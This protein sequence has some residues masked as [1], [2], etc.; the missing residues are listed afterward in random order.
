MAPRRRCV[1]CGGIVVARPRRGCPA[2]ARR[3]RP[4]RLERIGELK[5]AEGE[6]IAAMFPLWRGDAWGERACDDGSCA[7]CQRMELEYRLDEILAG[8]V[9]EIRPDAASSRPGAPVT[10]PV[11]LWK[12]S[13]GGPTYT[14]PPWLFESASEVLGA[15]HDR[16][17]EAEAQPV[18][19]EPQARRARARAI[20]EA[21]R[22][23]RAGRHAVALLSRWHAEAQRR[24]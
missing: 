17:R 18:S 12:L 15:L 8:E 21:Q 13:Y 4:L 22:R 24:P 9:F 23:L 3:Y 5:Q 2:H 19:L 11:I 16:L 6:E 10:E 14:L 7:W 20:T 1:R